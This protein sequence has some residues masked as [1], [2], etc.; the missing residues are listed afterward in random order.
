M[1]YAFKIDSTSVPY[2]ATPIAQARLDGATALIDDLRAAIQARRAVHPGL[3][4]SNHLGWHSDTQMLTWGGAA[5]RALADAAITVA[6]GMSHFNDAPVDDYQWSVS[7]WANVSPPGALNQI[8][9]HP[10]QLWAAVFY[11]DTGADEGA[12]AGGEILFEDPRYP[13]AT[14]NNIAFRLIGPDGKPSANQRTLNPKPGD[15]LVFP[16]WLRHGVKPYHGT[17]ERISIAI[18]INARKPAD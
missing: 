18:N 6:K 3:T 8:H 15:L 10:G 9:A 14:M 1:T 16:A 11:I 12:E 4:R 17:R 2:F 13:M 7:M 5:A